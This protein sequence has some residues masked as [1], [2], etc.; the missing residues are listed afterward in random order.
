MAI[1]IGSA[2]KRTAEIPVF[3]VNQTIK[4]TL[5]VFPDSAWALR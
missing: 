2:A 4:Q 1:A 5:A 3:I